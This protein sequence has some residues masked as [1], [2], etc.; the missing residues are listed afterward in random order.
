MASR[1]NHHYPVIMGIT[2]GCFCYILGLLVA[3]LFAVKWYNAKYKKEVMPFKSTHSICVYGVYITSLLCSTQCILMHV[4]YLFDPLYCTA[5]APLCTVI[6]GA[7]RCFLY[8]VWLERAKVLQSGYLTFVPDI[9]LQKL[10]PFY[11][12]CYWFIQ[13]VIISVFFRGRLATDS[14]PIHSA[15]HITSCHFDEWVEW[16]PIIATVADGF[17][18]LFF[19]ALFLYPLCKSIRAFKDDPDKTSQFRH[20]GMFSLAQSK[21][22]LPF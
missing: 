13:I 6:Y 10:L 5:G 19:L 21:V 8:G 20:V 15:G 1:L 17:N 16:V 2:I 3:Q 22:F 7:S 11:I 4:S 14:D 9:I 12:G 18:A